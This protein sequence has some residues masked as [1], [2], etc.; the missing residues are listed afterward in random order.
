MS[1]LLFVCLLLFLFL[2]PDHEIMSPLE[3]KTVCQDLFCLNTH[4]ILVL[5]WA[6]LFFFWFIYLIILNKYSV[7]ETSFVHFELSAEGSGAACGSERC[8]RCLKQ[9]TDHWTPCPRFALCS[10]KMNFVHWPHQTSSPRLCLCICQCKAAVAQRLEAHL[11]RIRHNTYI[12]KAEKKSWKLFFSKS[13]LIFFF[14]NNKNK[15]FEKLILVTCLLQVYILFEYFFK[16]FF[17]TIFSQFFLLKC[18]RTIFI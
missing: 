8:R 3:L 11:I 15:T 7:Y 1:F 16:N 9:V 5:S 17:Y 10:F 14:C 2:W 4:L 6:F 12:L 18:Y 13:K